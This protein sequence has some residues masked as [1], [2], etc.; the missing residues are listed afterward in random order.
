MRGAAGRRS[1][2][3]PVLV[4]QRLRVEREILKSDDLLRQGEPVRFTLIEMEKAAFQV[5][6][7]F[8]RAQG[9]RFLKSVT[10]FRAS[11]SRRDR[12]APVVVAAAVTHCHTC[13]RSSR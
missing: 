10:T 7:I 9:T 4:D 6:A 5:M 3:A 1:D 11:P 13:R 2:A 8:H 12:P